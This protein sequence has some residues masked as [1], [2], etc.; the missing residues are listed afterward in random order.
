MRK[1]VA[2]MQNIQRAFPSISK[3]LILSTAVV[4]SMFVSFSAEEA[5][6]GK[7]YKFTM[8]NMFSMNHPV[9]AAVKE[10]AKEL[11]KASDGRIKLQV[12]ASGAL[13]KGPNIFETVGNGAIDMGTTCSCYHGGIL[14]VAATAF[15]LPGDPR[16]ADEIMEFIY[17]EDTLKF[18]R[19][20]YASKN[21][22]YGAPL[23]WDGYTIVSKKPITTWEDL[24]KLKIRASGSIAK[25]LR[26]MEVPTVFIP[27]SEIYV[28]L[29]RGTIDAEISGS[30]AESYL[31]KTFEV[32]KYQTVPNI[33]GA[34][35]CEIILN[36]D[37]WQ[38]LP[39]DLKTVFD[40]ALKHCATRV[41]QIFTDDA[42][43]AK[44]KMEAKG[45]EYVQL[46]DSV[47]DQWME[48]SVEMWDD[49]LAKESP[50]SAAYIELVKK[51]LEK[52]GYTL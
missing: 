35:N 33:T 47:V 43:T 32:A 48:T 23:V 26:R 13:V 36:R 31:A 25:T 5:H 3:F 16:G 37:R 49:E 38:E 30:H 12:L 17:Q 29:S 15:A 51:D 20:A 46:P 9:T 7:V 39:D 6:A 14:P 18:F 11:K 44:S 24:K 2:S 4:F 28:A 19:D 8:Q 52:R 1:G 21:V 10:M 34:Q 42:S 45:A 40:N 50:L 27:F 41:A 22:V